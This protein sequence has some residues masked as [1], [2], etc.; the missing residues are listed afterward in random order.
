MEFMEFIKVIN[1]RTF[2]YQKGIELFRGGFNWNLQFRWY[3]VPSKI[4]HERVTDPSAPIASPTM[5]GGLFSIDR[6]YFEE[7]GTYDMGFDIWVL[8]HYFIVLIFK[9]L[10][11]LGRRKH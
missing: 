8:F 3:A 6:Q 9:L 4:S 7:L 5:A 2:A 11:C 1:D 10:I